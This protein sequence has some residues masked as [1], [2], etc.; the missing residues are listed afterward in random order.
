MTRRTATDR[1]PAARPFATPPADRRIPRGSGRLLAGIL[2]GDRAR[3]EA[4]TDSGTTW[5]AA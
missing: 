2:V 4:S 5:S 1:R 3:I